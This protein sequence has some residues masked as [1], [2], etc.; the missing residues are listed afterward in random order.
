MYINAFLHNK[1]MH[2][3]YNFERNPTIKLNNSKS[4]FNFYP[5]KFYQSTLLK[6]N[7]ATNISNNINKNCNIINEI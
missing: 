3:P 7:I 5:P 2:I 4:L 6:A 1:I